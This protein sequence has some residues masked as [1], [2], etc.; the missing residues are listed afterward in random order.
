M[1]TIN[2]ITFKT[3]TWLCPWVSHFPCLLQISLNAVYAIH[4]LAV[5]CRNIKKMDKY[6]KIYDYHYNNGALRYSETWRRSRSRYHQ[7]NQHHTPVLYQVVLCSYWSQ[8]LITPHCMYF[9][10]SNCL[11]CA[12]KIWMKK[13]LSLNV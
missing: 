3:L 5:S 11:A 1:I 10:N 6:K 13:N 7:H 9:I 2:N 12:N 8:F 4:H